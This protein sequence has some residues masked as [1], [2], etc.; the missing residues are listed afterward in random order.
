M[1]IRLIRKI[2]RK[3]IFFFNKFIFQHKPEFS[4]FYSSFEECTSKGNVW[5]SDEWVNNQLKKIQGIN[6]VINQKKSKSFVNYT[7]HGT[8]LGSVITFINLLSQSQE[9]VRVVDFGGG[10]G[11]TYHSCV[12]NLIEPNKVYWKIIDNEIL[13]NL[14]NRILISDNSQIEYTS[15]INNEKYDILIIGSTLHYIEDYKKTMKELLR[16]NPNIIHLER[17]HAGEISNNFVCLQK[18]N[19]SY[20]PIMNLNIHEFNMFMN[21]NGY[22]LVYKA[23][24][25]NENYN[26]KSFSNDIPKDYRIRYSLSLTYKKSL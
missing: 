23:N 3:L 26:D 14:S 7:T 4:G 16:G 15:S 25:D 21:D 12:L 17:L 19:N 11:I 13:A 2:N 18:Y 8:S 24:Q 22:T 5:E 20:T 9:K 1:M 6:S 10:T